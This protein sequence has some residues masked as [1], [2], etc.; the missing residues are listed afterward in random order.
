MIIADRFRGRAASAARTAGGFAVAG[1]IAATG[2]V[3]PAGAAS[4]A[5]ATGSPT[6]AHTARAPGTATSATSTSTRALALKLDLGAMPRGRLMIGAGKMRLSEYGLTPGSRHGVAIVFHRHEVAIGTLT[7]NSVGAG[8][9]SYSSSAARAATYRAEARAALRPASGRPAIRL[10]ILNAGRGTPVIAATLAITGPGSYPVRGVEPG[11]GV[12]KAGSAIL[13]YN[14]VA[15]TISVTVNAAGLTPGAHAAHIHVGSC[16]RQGAVVYA[17]TDFTANSRGVIANE[18]RTVRGVAA[19]KF[20]G[21]YFNLHQGNSSNILNRAG[22]P[23]IYFRP[24]EC[25]NL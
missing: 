25:A 17:F 2:L 13:V 22:Q 14:P 24:L 19:V 3:L 20:S 15:A 12:I 11:Y 1:A 5:P 8:S 9:W 6:A 7:A 23:T 21:W 16:Q 18:T 4:G 10:V